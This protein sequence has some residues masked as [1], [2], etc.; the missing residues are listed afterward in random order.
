MGYWGR[1]DEKL[2][3]H[4][5]LIMDLGF[6]ENYNVELGRMNNGKKGRTLQDF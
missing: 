5:M 6:V 1:V 4:G 2:I 3:K